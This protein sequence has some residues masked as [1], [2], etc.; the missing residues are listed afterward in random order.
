MKYWRPKTENGIWNWL[1]WDTEH[2]L[3]L[4]YSAY[5]ID[6]GSPLW[7]TLDWATGTTGPR[8]WNGG[9]T[10]IIR[11]LLE[12][13]RVKDYFIN[14]YCDL[15]NSYFKSDY[16]L[17]LW[18]KKA[19]VIEADVPRQLGRWGSREFSDWQSS[20]D[21]VEN[22]L[23][24]RPGYAMQHLKEKFSLSDSNMLT[25]MAEPPEAGRIRVNTLKA[26]TFPWQG[27]YFEDVPITLKALPEPGYKFSYWVC[28]DT[29]LGKNEITIQLNDSISAC[30][31]FVPAVT[32]N[33]IINEINYNSAEHYDTEDWVE[34]YN[35]NSFDVD[36]SGWFLGDISSNYE[37]PSG[38]EIKGNGFLVICK[39]LEK[40]NTF[41]DSI[42][43]V[44][45]SFG[46]DFGLS[47]KGDQ[48]RLLN[49]EMQLIDSLEYYDKAP[50]P[51]IA[52][53]EGMTIEL[54]EYSLNNLLA[55][56]WSDSKTIGGTPG[57]EN[58]VF[59]SIEKKFNKDIKFVLKA[60]YPNPFNPETTISYHIERYCRVKITVFNIL[61]QKVRTLV[62][63]MQGAGS[64]NVVFNAEGLADGVYLYRL[65]TSD[66]FS[67]VRKM[68]LIK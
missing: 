12:N 24:A 62:N 40:F 44:I 28:S 55:S 64:Y 45:G 43:N 61:G 13:E 29:L 56:S 23:A 10:I 1:L 37:I 7:N 3:G 14:R 58:S 48:V 38:I 17:P 31:V 65:S 49:S 20:L 8:V 47:G 33:L 19:A 59:T 30:A 35:P 2:G 66:G 54:K 39:D 18:R 63:R 25:L 21:I 5:D 57:R 26:D 11:G 50:W 41:N 16:L 6:F 52:D 34:I 68:M 46:D 42:S 15:L 32:K 60:N 36:I 27:R 67:A 22:Y 4:P 9:N 51:Q 53:G